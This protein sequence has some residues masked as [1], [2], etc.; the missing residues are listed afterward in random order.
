MLNSSRLTYCFLIEPPGDAVVILGFFSG[1]S[2]ASPGGLVRETGRRGEGE[3]ELGIGLSLDVRPLN[4][5]NLLNLLNS[6]K[7]YCFIWRGS[8]CEN[9]FSHQR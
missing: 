1:G 5:L 6:L 7:L 3:G 2:T 8:L 4:L 9:C